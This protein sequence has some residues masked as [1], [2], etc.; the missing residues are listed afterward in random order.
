[1]PTLPLYQVDAFT[2]RPF[3]G[4]PAA[5]CPLDGPL[6]DALMQD[7]AAENNL[8]ETA[9]FH[10]RGDAFS[11][12]WFTPTVEV[13]LCGHATLAS[14]FVQMTVLEPTRTELVFHTRSGPLP[15]RRA[16]DGFTMDFPT[17]P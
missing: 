16:D 10:A 14:A 4:N 6:P 15:V 13:D 5:V 11:L 12:R 2:N 3:A 7:I 1:M 17:R 9:F 8:S